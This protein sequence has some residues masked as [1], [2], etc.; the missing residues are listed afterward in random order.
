MKMVLFKEEVQNVFE[1]KSQD[2]KMMSVLVKIITNYIAST[3]QRGFIQLCSALVDNCGKFSFDSDMRMED[4]S[5]KKLE[6]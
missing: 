1:K 4:D 2:N 6:I 3:L 5:G